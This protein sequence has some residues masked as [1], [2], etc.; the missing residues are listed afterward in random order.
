[1]A[2]RRSIAWLLLWLA[3]TCLAGPVEV[4]SV[5]VWAA[6]DNTRVVLDVSGPVAHELF[7]LSGPDRVV[8]DLR[9]A[10]IKGFAQSDLGQGLIKSLRSGVRNGTDL[11][12][13]LDTST[14]V[15]PRSFLLKPN[16]EYGHRLVVDL[17]E[18]G[19]PATASAPAAKPTV[20]AKA[21][22]KTAARELVI[23]IDAGHGGEDPGARGRKGTREKDVVL[24]IARDLAALVDKEPGMRA[25][26]IRD[27][28]YFIPLRKRM[29][30][31]REH[32][33]DLFVSI[34][35]DAFKDRRAH[36]SSVYVVSERGASSEMARILA[37]QENA[38][39]LVGGVSLNDKDDLL[40]TVLLD[41][42]RA[43]S[44]E[45]STEVADNVLHELKQIGRVHKH[46]VQ[47]AGFVVLKSPDVPSILVETAFISNPQEEL[48]LR[49][50]GHQRKLAQAVMNGVRAYFRSNPPTGTLMA[51]R[52]H[53]IKRGDTL[54]EIAKRY[55]VSMQRLRIANSLPDD[56]LRV[57]AVLRIPGEDS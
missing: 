31:A 56:T 12:L 32:R 57:G 39:D 11:R 16:G 28:D 30:K 55:D 1:M 34:H 36:G 15:R 49:D 41:L 40:R 51:T 38:S 45:A 43:A 33:A 20:T 27:G 4:Q 7:T 42:S 8:I 2:S 24:Q 25:V 14:A 3:G 35:A 9:G 23:A 29:Q 52:E 37:D 6:P 22:P 26:L 18:A 47:Q 44:I 48:K 5:R 54:S 21:A 10:R 17:Y 19:Q 50:R 53:V 13:V 46:Q